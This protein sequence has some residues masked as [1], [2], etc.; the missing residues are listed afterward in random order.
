MLVPPNIPDDRLEALRRAYDATMKDPDFLAEAKQRNMKVDPRT[1]EQIEAVLH[2][3]A[4]LPPELIAKAGE[5][6]RK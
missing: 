5:M 2:A 4:A 6:A 1:G 3:V